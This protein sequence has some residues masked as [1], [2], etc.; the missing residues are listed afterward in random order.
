M[1]KRARVKLPEK[2]ENN[3][4]VSDDKDI[5]FVPTGCTV[6]DCTLG[7]GYALGR[8]SNIIGDKSTAKTA[9]ATEAL[10]NFCLR[11]PDG[12][13]A[14]RD[15]EAAFDVRYA[16][17]M[18]VPIK[19]IDFGDTDLV[20]IEDFINEYTAFLNA[21]I[22]DKKPSIYVLDSMDSLSD[23]AEMDRPIEKGSF[24]MAK[25][26]LLSEFFRKNTR[27]IEK[28]NS[29]LLIVS[30]VREN[31]NAAAFGEKYRRAGGKALD[32]YASQLL[33]LA[34]V[35]QLKRTIKKV[36]RPYGV[37]IRAK[38][39]KNKVGLPFRECDFDFIF[40]YGVEDLGASL[41]WL[42]DVHRVSELGISDRELKEFKTEC[43]SLPDDE[44]AKE[45]KR[46]AKIVKK[47]WA[48]IETSF[49]PTRRKYS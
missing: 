28:A 40:G 48:E 16:E 4:F 19:D 47:V 39:K 17:A 1:T 21:R 15:A 37:T 31:I 5:Q 43:E 41:D 44:Y 29:L 35:G 42:K 36:E 10:T 49:I 13:A 3:Y 24:G 33:W 23:D 34:H 18:G 27:K 9:L 14:Y 12:V 45:T 22:K 46:V 11:Y 8:M 38:C 2:K 26:K 6:L 30:Q 20:T 32:F 7:G 25:A